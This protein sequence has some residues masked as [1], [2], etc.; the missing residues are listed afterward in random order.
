VALVHVH[1]HVLLQ[2]AV[3]G[4]G[5]AQVCALGH[6]ILDDYVIVEVVKV[7]VIQE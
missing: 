2:A 5:D 3:H 6:D 4:H 1:V 7:C